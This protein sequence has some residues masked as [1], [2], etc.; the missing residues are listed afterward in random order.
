[1]GQGAEARPHSVPRG[2]AL[3]A[4]EDS[5]AGPAPKTRFLRARC[6]SRRRRSPSSNVSWRH[7]RAGLGRCRLLVAPLTA[8]VRPTKRGCC[9]L[10]LAAVPNAC[11]HAQEQRGPMLRMLP[12]VV[13]TLLIA[14][15][16][17]SGSSSGS[18][19]PGDKQSCTC[20]GG[21][22]GFQTCDAA[23][24]FGACACVG[25]AGGGVSTGGSGT[26]SA[27]SSM[28]TSTSGAGG[29]DAGSDGG[30]AG[31]D[32]GDGGLL[33][34]MSPCT[35]NAQCDTGLCWDFPTKGP[36]CSKM[37]ATDADC[38]APS[39]GCNPQGVCRAP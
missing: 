24:N 30:D 36:H 7:H 4:A 38:P 31:M 12:A 9:R 29:A 3:A 33:P 17:C 6:R 15:A 2:Q 13:A 32:A 5:E 35:T 34:F 16:A 21:M 10:L 14:T 1:V 27:A 19:F 37:C 18:C 22:S 25:G 11:S 23:G 28:S 20:K 8:P 26:S 39:P